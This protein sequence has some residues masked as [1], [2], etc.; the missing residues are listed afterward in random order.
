MFVFESSYPFF[1]SMIMGG[2]VANIRIIVVFFCAILFTI[3]ETDSQFAPE[4]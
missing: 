2:R 4:K 3:P 1:T